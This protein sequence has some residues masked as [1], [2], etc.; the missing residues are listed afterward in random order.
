MVE[1]RIEKTSIKKII[2]EYKAYKTISLLNMTKITPNIWR[3]TRAYQEEVWT[4][5]YITRF[6]VMLAI[7]IL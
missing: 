5:Y 7:E 3:S 1:I 2:F 4:L 6:K